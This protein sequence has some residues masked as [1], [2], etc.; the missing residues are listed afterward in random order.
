M[1]RPRRFQGSLGASVVVQDRSKSK[2]ARIVEEAKRGKKKRDSDLH[3]SCS[4]E[5][6]AKVFDGT[7]ESIQVHK[8]RQQARF[9]GHLQQFSYEHHGRGRITVS[10]KCSMGKG[11]TECSLE[12]VAIF[13]RILTYS[14]HKAS[15]AKAC[16][17][18]IIILLLVRLACLIKAQ[19]RWHK[20]QQAG[21]GDVRR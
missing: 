16:R 20:P 18:V 2:A 17:L 3:S 9:S 5:H 6:H 11:G 14:L 8:R 15:L 12:C 19:T 13:S 7:L 1:E 4:N 10:C 21:E